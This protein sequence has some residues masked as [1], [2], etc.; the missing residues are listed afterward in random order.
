MKYTFRMLLT[1]IASALFALNAVTLLL[2]VFARENDAIAFATSFIVVN[3][4]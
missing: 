1:S 4:A 3:E 2:D